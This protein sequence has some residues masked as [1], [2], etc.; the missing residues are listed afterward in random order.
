MTQHLKVAVAQLACLPNDALAS[1]R[2][3]A[4][5]VRQASQQGARLVVFPEAFL[6][7][8]PKGASFGAPIGMRKPEGRDAFAR[9]HRAAIDL[10]GPEVALMAEACAETQAHLEAMGAEAL[11]RGDWSRVTELARHASQLPR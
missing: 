2:K 9:Y 5:A 6:G 8:Y 11:A 1:A 10:N 7:G 4:D 3:A